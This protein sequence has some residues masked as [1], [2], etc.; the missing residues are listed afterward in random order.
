MHFSSTR[1]SRPIPTKTDRSSVCSTSLGFFGWITASLAAPVVQDI[2]ARV[3]HT[4]PPSRS[5]NIQCYPTEI[6][7]ENQNFNHNH[8]KNRYK[9]TIVIK[10][11]KITHIAIRTLVENAT[12]VGTLLHS[13]LHHNLRLITTL[14]ACNEW[15][16]RPKSFWKPM[17][18]RGPGSSCHL[19]SIL[20]F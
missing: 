14:A 6:K 13:V 2:F 12:L 11:D 18:G 9:L 7:I 4:L 10:Y 20:I 19:L 16:A 17:R 5:L 1:I 3:Q 8:H 15:E